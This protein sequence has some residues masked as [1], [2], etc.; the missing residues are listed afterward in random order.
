[1]TRVR[2]RGTRRLVVSFVATALI[3]SWTVAVPAAHAFTACAPGCPVVANEADYSVSYSPA[4]TKLSVNGA[5]G[6]LAG[7]SGPSTTVVDLQDTPDVPG[8]NVVTTLQGFTVTIN[9]NG[10]FSYKADPSFSGV[11]SFDYYIWDSTNHDNYDINTVYITV[12]PVVVNDSYGIT[13]GHTLIVAA[14]GVTGN[15][16]GVDPTSLT[17]DVSSANGGLINDRGNGGFDYT[18]PPH[19]TG[20]DT[21]SYDIWDLDTDNDYTGVV[22]VWVFGTATTVPDPPTGVVATTGNGPATVA[23]TPPLN[24]GGTAITAYAAACTSTNGGATA[25]ASGTASPL[26]VTGLTNGDNYACT[27]TATNSVGTSAPSAPSNVFVPTT[28]PDPPTGVVATTGNGS[29]SV[30]FTPPLNDGGTAITAYAAACTSTNGGATAAASGTAS[31]LVVTGLTNGDNYA[32]TVTATNSVGTSAPSAPSNVFVPT[33]VPDP[34]TGVV[35]TTGNGS[36]SVAFTPPLNDGGTAITAYAAACTSTNGG[37]TAAASGTASPLVVTG[38]TNGD[39]YA[40]TVTATNSVGTSAPSAPSSV[41]TPLGCT[42]ACVSVGDQSMLE[43]DAGMHTMTFPVTLSMPAA[44]TVTVQYAVRGITATGGTSSAPGVDFLLKNGTVT[45]KPNTTTGKT[46]TKINVTVTVYGDTNA[47]PD[48]TFGV[49]LSNPTGGYT[50]G[51]NVGTGTILNDD[52]VASGTTIGI[53]DSSIV[54]AASG[55][56]KLGVPVALSRTMASTVSVHYTVTPSSASYSAKAGGGS[57]FGGTLTGTLKF[58]AGTKQMMINVPI[59]SDPNADPDELFTITLSGLVGTGVTM[60][61]SQS[62][63]VILGGY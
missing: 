28:V 12:V 6:V 22:S 59:W 39:N 55:N 40:C 37:A 50:L 62:T 52:G 58:A 3:A 26:V 20:V 10:S 54:N 49:T 42:S 35:A 46:P 27:V 57:D 14:P 41:F 43:G 4:G 24:D 36:A 60:L 16:L 31:P 9:S 45:F 17:F 7:D 8:T 25:A 53:G 21:F 63:Q 47:E 51:R 32:C 38:L 48:E 23:F 13:A 30:A 34:P 11:D 44:T 15:D 5:D 33:T 1:M 56:Q 29:A 2:M 19:F 18:P 61:R